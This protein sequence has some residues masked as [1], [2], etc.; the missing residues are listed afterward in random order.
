MPTQTGTSY[1]GIMAAQICP[2]IDAITELLPT[3]ARE[4]QECVKTGARWVHLR[5]CQTC[6]ATLCCDAS[7]NRH[8][9]T[10]ALATT[11]GVFASAEPD[12]RWVYCFH[13]DAFAE[14]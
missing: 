12:E 8:A 2:H 7:P 11:H 3:K 14:Y 4:C 6:G 1:I 5:T 13:D 9:R 10:H